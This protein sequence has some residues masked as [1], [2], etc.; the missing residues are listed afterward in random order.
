MVVIVA[1]EFAGSVV[2][3]ANECGIDSWDLGCVVPGTGV[4]RFDGQVL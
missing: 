3:R 1:A 4:V 2:S